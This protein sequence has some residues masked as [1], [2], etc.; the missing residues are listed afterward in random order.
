VATLAVGGTV[1]SVQ[2]TLMLPILPDFPRLLDT[3]VDNAS[4]L[5][6]ATLLAGA[7]AIP[8]LSRLADMYGKKRMILAAYVLMVAGAVIGALSRDL[9]W[10]I[11]ARALQGAGLAVVPIG[12][13][14]MRDELPRGRLPLGVA[15]M[16]ATLA[17]GSGA[18]LPLAGVIV[19]H[20][21]WH[22]IFWIT[23]IA[24]VASFVAVWAIVPESPVRSGGSFDYLGALALSAGVT[25]L[26]LALSKGAYWGWTSRPT[27][28]LLVAGLVVLAFWVR[29]ELGSASPLVDLRV[30]VRPAVLLVNVASVLVG[31]AMFMNMVG[32]TQLLQVPGAGGLGLDAFHA[33]LWMAPTALVFG[34]FAPLSASM[35]KWIGPRLTLLAGSLVMA[36]AYLARAL[37]SDRLGQVVAGAVVVGVGTS[38]TYAAMP[39]LVMAAVPATETAQANGLNTLLRSVGT[40]TASATLAALSTALAVTVGGIGHPGPAAFTA[41]FSIASAG[42]LGAGLLALGLRAPAAHR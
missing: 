24:C 19:T 4:W 12:I 29:L 3:T 32:T 27:L 42:C 7:I 6:T 20:A 36:V 37:A 25:A 28:L 2:Q 13:A 14:I 11:A 34:A 41:G 31:F 22:S 8:T 21:D 9:V 16:S 33:G 10:L 17:I 1:V 5:V 23:G 35:I 40:S 26:L 38:M 30:A 18:A 15:L 39:N